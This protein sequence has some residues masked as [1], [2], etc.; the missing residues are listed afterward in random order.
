MQEISAGEKIIDGVLDANF[1][2]H[3]TGVDR[4]LGDNSVSLGKFKDAQSLFDAYNS[5]QSEFTRRCQRVKELERENE[6]LNKEITNASKNNLSSGVIEQEDVKKVAENTSLK[7]NDGTE[8]VLAQQSLQEQIDYYKSREYLFNA[9]NENQDVKD[10]IIN[11]YLNS[12]QSSKPTVKLMTGNGS[13]VVT[14]P[15]KPKTLV[16]AGEIA[17]QI[18]EN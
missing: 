3:T 1:E 7:V 4:K 16:E 13:S 8:E 2:S 14:P 9:L 5:L 11:G 17:R 18:F 15:S 12:V 6:R 10:E